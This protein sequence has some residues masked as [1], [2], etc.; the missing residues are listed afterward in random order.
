MD[1]VKIV[2]SLKDEGT[3]VFAGDGINDAPVIVEAD[4]G[5]AMGAMGSDAAIET[6]DIVIMDDR[7][8]K[9]PKAVRLSKRTQ[10][11][12]WQ[13]IAFVLAVKGLFVSLGALGL[14]TMWEAVFADVGVSLMTA[15]NA[16]RIFR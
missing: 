14:A 7:V 12:V 1:K 5:I 11:I 15:L 13:N 10:S 6:A 9:I 2:R 3:T 16:L 8:S 4:V